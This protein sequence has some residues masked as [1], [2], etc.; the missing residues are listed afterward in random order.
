M[1]LIHFIGVFFLVPSVLMAQ[2]GGDTLG[3]GGGYA[4]LQIQKLFL[5]FD[6]EIQ[7][8]L[9]ENNP[10]SLITPDIELLKELLQKKKGYKEAKIEFESS[11]EHWLFKTKPQFDSTVVINQSMLYLVSGEAISLSLQM[12]YV[13]R[14][15]FFQMGLDDYRALEVSQRVSKF[16]QVNMTRFSGGPAKEA[17]VTVGAKSEQTFG[18]YFRSDDQYV[19]AGPHLISSIPC[20]VEISRLR[21]TSGS[22]NYVD[23]N[24]LFNGKLAYQCLNSKKTFEANFHVYYYRELI[25][26]QGKL[27]VYISQV[28]EVQ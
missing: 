22:F 21:I 26:S 10:C 13:L 28:T 27:S 16:W 12:E 2:S 1:K 9:Q 24:K 8:C 7:I 5:S 6:Q 18:F 3:N 15:Y 23:R 19:D 4:E 20:H 17:Y 14:I 25:N 11:P